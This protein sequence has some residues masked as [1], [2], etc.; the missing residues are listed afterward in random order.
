[1]ILHIDQQSQ[2]SS[3][4]SALFRWEALDKLRRPWYPGLREDC[5]LL[6]YGSWVPSV[7]GASGKT[8]FSFIMALRHGRFLFDIVG[9]YSFRKDSLLPFIIALGRRRFSFDMAS[10]QSFR[11]YALL[12]SLQIFDVVLGASG[13]ALLSFITTLRYGR[14]SER[15]ERPPT[16][17]SVAGFL[18]DAGRLTYTGHFPLIL[19]LQS[20]STLALAYILVLAR[21]N[22]VSLTLTCNTFDLNRIFY[23]HKWATNFFRIHT[24]SDI[25][26]TACSSNFTFFLQRWRLEHFIAI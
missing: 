25:L 23:D 22:C 3:C 10:S 16:L 15:H 4:T 7:L 6:H 11:K 13:K 2:V 5:L 20:T 19:Q 14:F 8:P 12:P 17:S 21:F 24:L 18:D 9:S 1:M 26:N